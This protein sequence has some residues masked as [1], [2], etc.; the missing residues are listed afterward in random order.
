MC[1]GD[2][3]GG[4]GWTSGFRWWLLGKRG[5]TFFGGGGG[6]AIFWQK[7]NQNLEYLMTKTL[8]IQTGKILTKN[9][10]TFKR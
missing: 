10:V 9:L 1:T 2:G 3:G 6:G 5:M 4:G 8:R 7:T